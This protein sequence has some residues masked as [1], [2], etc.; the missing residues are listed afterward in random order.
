MKERLVR[1]DWAMKK[2]LRNKANFEIL[3]GFLSEL[4][5]Q[6]V[7]IQN[8]LE[9]ES[10]KQSEDDK[11]N[12]VDLLTEIDSGE[13]VLIELQVGG[14]YDYFHRMLYG[15]SKLITDHMDAGF[16]YDKV[17]K[18]ISINIVYFDLGHGDDYVF[19]LGHIHK[20]QINDNVTYVGTPYPTNL[21][22]INY[23]FG[24]MVVSDS[25][26][27]KRKKYNWGFKT[28]NIKSLEQL[29]KE[30]IDDNTKIV[31]HLNDIKE[32]FEYIHRI[33]KCL[34][35]E[36]ILNKI[37]SAQ[38]KKISGSINFKDMLEEYCKLIKKEELFDICLKY[39]EENK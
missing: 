19:I 34:Y 4:L 20:Y 24:I 11:Y 37:I 12:R 17:R 6:D 18:I 8:I 36:I 35:V 33:K 30:E 15:S 14:Q 7:K 29:E 39:A 2:L 16:N 5:L 26:E 27:F 21:G 22:E 3:E 10:N 23:D 9:S 25:G 32:K 1:F 13:L 38:K 31:L 28:I